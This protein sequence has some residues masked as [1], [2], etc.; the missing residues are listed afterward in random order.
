M[1]VVDR[2]DASHT[3]TSALRWA[4]RLKLLDCDPERDPARTMLERLDAP[5]TLTAIV[6][7]VSGGA[8]NIRLARNLRACMD[9]LGQPCSPIHLHS[10]NS[11]SLD[12]LLRRRPNSG[13][14]LSS[15]SESG[16][17]LA[18]TE[19]VIIEPFGRADALC[20]I[21]H[22]SSPREILA[23]RLHEA[24]CANRN[25]AHKVASAEDQSLKPWDEL[26]ETYRRA[27]RRAADQ[28]PMKWLAANHHA[29]TDLH[30]PSFPD[31]IPP[32]HLEALAAM[33]HDSWRID[34]ELDGWR[35]GETRDNKRLLHPDLVPYGQL[36]ETSK[37]FCRQQI[38]EILPVRAAADDVGRTKP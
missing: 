37:E 29:G 28:L 9:Q 30:L 23:R 2:D 32:E 25:Q 6:V 21:G 24:H 8:G 22:A 34:R 31:Q 18:A 36:R 38:R 27:S 3:D 19:D 11:T 4:A 7:A 5:E 13:S 20:R 33:E 35:H 26:G 10:P 16:V 14:S 1:A 17:P 12:S 15:E